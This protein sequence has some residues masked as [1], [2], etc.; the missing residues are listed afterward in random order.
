MSSTQPMKTLVQCDFDGTITEEDVSFLML[1]AF[2]DGD[3]RGVH[4][5]YQ[6]AKISVGRFNEDAFAMVRA[7]K[8]SLLKAIEGKFNIRSG[9][10]EF[11]DCCRRKDF[12]LVIVS[13]GLD[14]Y[15][16]EILKGLGL[17][18]I[19][20]HAARTRFL[21]GQVKVQYVGPDG[22]P[23]D[24]AFKEAYVDFFLGQGYRI[25]YIGDGASDFLPARKCHYVFATGTSGTLLTRCRQAKLDCIPFSDFNEVVKVL[26]HL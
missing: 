18:G 3:W 23:L 2:A 6:E 24:D 17:D 25:I 26:E 21:P 4:K 5:L 1:D 16:E 22:K 10:P 7:D 15:I 13:N 20:I 9:F 19:E 12:R 8:K 14:F 11:V